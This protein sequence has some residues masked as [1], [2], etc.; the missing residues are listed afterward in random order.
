[1]AKKFLLRLIRG[2]LFVMGV[3]SCLLSFP[4][5]AQNSTSTPT[6]GPAPAK[7]KQHDILNTALSAQTRQTLQEAM[8]SARESDTTHP[9]PAAK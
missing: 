6:I 3:F 4:A 7:S 2:D 5:L 9:V 8:N 1:M